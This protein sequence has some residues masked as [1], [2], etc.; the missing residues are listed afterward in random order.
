MNSS[1]LLIPWIKMLIILLLLVIMCW[2]LYETYI[3][4]IKEY[5]DEVIS[6]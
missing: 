2:V 1:D 5:D 3:K 6:K 4:D